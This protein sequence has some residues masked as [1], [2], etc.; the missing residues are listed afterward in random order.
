MLVPETTASTLTAGYLQQQ[1]VDRY[2]PYRT[3]DSGRLPSPLP[4]EAAP[5]HVFS[6]PCVDGVL[7]SGC[8]VGCEQ[9]APVGFRLDPVWRLF[10]PTRQVVARARLLGT[11]WLGAPG[12][13]NTVEWPSSAFLA[14]HPLHRGL[15]LKFSSAGQSLAPLWTPLVPSVQVQVQELQ[16]MA[17]PLAKKLSILCRPNFFPVSNVRSGLLAMLVPTCYSYYYSSINLGCLDCRCALHVRG[18]SSPLPLLQLG[19]IRRQ[20]QASLF[21]STARASEYSHGLH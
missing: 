16:V 15:Q 12:T 4:K 8:A 3:L 6:Q 17:V 21:T 18:S 10:P 13:D 5:S 14:L 11:V 2:L 20:P 7:A 9:A 19:H 1:V